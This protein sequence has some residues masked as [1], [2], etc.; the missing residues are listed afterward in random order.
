M[1]KGIV[2]KR[3][4]K[5]VQD[6]LHRKKNTPLGKKLRGCRRGVKNWDKHIFQFLNTITAKRFVGELQ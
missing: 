5:S 6:N 2:K 4:Q 3:L 1:G